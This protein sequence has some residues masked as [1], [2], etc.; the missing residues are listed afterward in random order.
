MIIRDSGL[1]FWATLYMSNATLELWYHRWDSSSNGP[2]PQCLW[3][4]VIGRWTFPDL[5]P[6]YGW[7]STTLWV[8]C[9]LWASQLGQLAFHPIAVDKW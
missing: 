9:P 1:L 6:I 3:T 2:L 4:S 8:N 7:Q 5:C